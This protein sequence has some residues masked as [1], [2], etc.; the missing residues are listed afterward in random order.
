MI[1]KILIGSAVV[2]IILII[3]GAIAVNKWT[4][5]PYGKL[6]TTTA[7]F[8]K[9]WETIE[10]D[11]NKMTP[12]EYRREMDTQSAGSPGKITQVPRVLDDVIKHSSGK[13]PIRIY[14]PGKKEKMP[15]IIYFHGGG[16]VVGNIETCDRITRYLAEKSGSIVV[17]VNYSLA[18]EKT[19][20]AAV[21]DAYSALLWAAQ[22]AV[23]LGGDPARIAVA[24]DS[25]GGNLAAVVSLMARDKRGP[26]IKYQILIYPATD[27]SSMNT[28]SYNNFADGFFLQKKQM[29]WFC[30][31]YLPDKKER[32]NPYAS[33]LLAKSHN[34]LPKAV[35]ITAQFDPLRDEGEAYADK[36]KQAGVPIRLKRYDGMI[37]GFVSMDSLVAQAFQALDFI[38]DELKAGG[39]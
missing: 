26:K 31:Q 7:I 3:A 17:S 36:L 37:H 15:V 39:F 30:D 22:N 25:A 28:E 6:D 16:W 18:P 38:T 34:N 5:T 4:N 20:P 29:Q 14:L 10:P 24:G 2:L 11:Y 35:I 32:Q 8:I 19:F 27:L 33:P 23:T 12:Q 13:I 1:K 21:N 9:I